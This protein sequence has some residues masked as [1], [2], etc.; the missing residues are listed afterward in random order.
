[1]ITNIHI[2]LIL[3]NIGYLL[4]NSVSLSLII[5][6]KSNERES[7]LSEK[8]IKQTDDK[9]SDRKPSFLICEGIAANSPEPERIKI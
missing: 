8:K 1:M 9:W 2:F 5:L 7:N 6:A 4:R 3:V